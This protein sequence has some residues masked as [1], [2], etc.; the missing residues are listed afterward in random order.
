MHSLDCPLHDAAKL[1]LDGLS[2][3]LVVAS[4]LDKIAHQRRELLHLCLDVA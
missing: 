4:K 2:S 1:N 3:L